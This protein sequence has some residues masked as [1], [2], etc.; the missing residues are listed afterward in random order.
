MAGSIT[1]VETGLSTS[2]TEIDEDWQAQGFYPLESIQFLPGNTAADLLIVRDRTVD[3]AVIYYLQ[4]PGLKSSETGMYIKYFNGNYH[5]P[6]I[7]FSE[8]VLSAGHEVLIEKR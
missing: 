5:Q 8:C 7:D 6:Y 1:V 4:A 2:I 3:G